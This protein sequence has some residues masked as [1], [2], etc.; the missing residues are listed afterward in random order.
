[1]KPLS[2]LL[3]TLVLCAP[4]QAARAQDVEP[5]D[6]AI[7]ESVDLRGL[8]RESLSPGLRRELETL[9]GEPLNRQHL[10]ELAARIEGEQP[11]VVAAVRYLSRPDGQARVI[12]LVV[13]IGEDSNL[14]ENINARYTVE[15][16]EIRGIDEDE[17]RQSLR[18]RVRALVGRRLDHDEAEELSDELEDEHPGYSVDR[19]I[20]RGSERGRIRV[21]FEFRE[22]EG[23]RWIPFVPSRSKFVFH[24]DQRGS[25]ALD[26]PMGGRYHRFTA[27]FAFGN[28]DDLIEEY[29]GIRFRLESRRLGTERLGA[30]LEVSR[31][32]QDWRD[33]TVDALAAD[34]TIPGL[35]RT[36][37]TVEPKVTVAL[38]P[39][40]RVT[41]GASI[42][43]LEPLDQS[44]DSQM[45]SA[46]IASIDFQRRWNHH[47][48]QRVQ[49]GYELRSAAT[50]LESDLVYKRHLGKARYRYERN[51]STVIADV[52]F[53]GITGTA[54]LF[55]RFSLGDTTTLRGWN[56]Y[57]IA[58]TGG[59]RVFHSSLEYRLHQLG[60]FLDTGSV[61][62][63]NTDP[64]IRLSTG[65][66]LQHDNVFITFGFP[67]N[68]DDVRATFMMGVRF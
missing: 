14:V 43:E 19:S 63:R 62:N 7:I 17:I 23:E 52:F 33:A 50:G 4:W 31:L 54:P 56:K 25:G 1:M 57:D 36:R 64:T 51:D 32:R 34:P 27:G 39:F 59:E 42:T 66:G 53:G 3:L 15:S 37:L 2:L 60:F 18:D 47:A 28:N 21:V 40:L 29:T 26:I 13:R 41:G 6:G 65:F 46:F 16:V 58:P 44:L 61:W 11:D 45:A 24:E 8:P 68:T 9:T 20:S 22:K 10:S 12:L 49:A 48:D 38:N 5:P 55:E 30:S 35:Y 67:L